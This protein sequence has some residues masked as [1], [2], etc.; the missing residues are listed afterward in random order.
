MARDSSTVVE[1][2]PHFLMVKGLS[3]LEPGREN[4][5]KILFGATVSDSYAV[6]FNIA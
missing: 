1:H 4:I 2:S 5:L 6:S 3:Q